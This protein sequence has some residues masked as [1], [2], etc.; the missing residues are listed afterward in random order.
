M[1]FK[2]LES[3]VAVVDEGSFSNA[4]DRL[5]LSQSMVTIHVRNLEAELGARLLNRTTRSMELSADGKTFYYYA[6][7]MLRLHRDSMFALTR[8]NQDERCINIVA[9]PYTGRY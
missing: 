3:F 8:A 1:D 2:Q 5:Q 9:T 6:K 4:A 7:Q